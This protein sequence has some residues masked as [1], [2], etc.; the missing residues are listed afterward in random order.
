MEAESQGKIGSA[1]LAKVAKKYCDTIEE[2]GY[3]TGIYS[4]ASWWTN[5]LTNSYFKTK[6]KWIARYPN[7]KNFNCTYQDDYAMW[8]CNSDAKVDG[9]TGYV[10]LNYMFQDIYTN[11]NLYAN[12]YSGTYDGKEHSITVSNYKEGTKVQ[13]STDNLTWTTTNPVRIKAG[14]TKVYY[15]ATNKAGKEVTGSAKIIIKTVKMSDVSVSS[16]GN[17]TYTGSQI[18]PSVTVKYNGKTLKKGTDYTVTYGVNKSVGTGSVRVTGIGNYS[19]SQK[20]IFHIVPKQVSG[21]SAYKGKIAKSAILKWNKATGATG[22]QVAYSRKGMNKWSYTTVEGTTKTF[23]GLTVKSYDVKVRAYKTV[24]GKK[25]YGS[26]SAVKA[27]TV[28]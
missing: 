21:L 23:Q 13:Y 12:D 14:T 16:I 1:N 28:K 20:I 2:A 22:Y 15:K 4:G 3:T 8:Q 24:N 19:D 11:L 5:K 9:I 25:K 7:V 10:D 18:K 27:M 17:Q 6:I 26:Y